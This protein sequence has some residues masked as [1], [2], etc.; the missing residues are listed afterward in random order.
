MRWAVLGE[1][2]P[3]REGVYACGLRFPKRRTRCTTVA[4]SGTDA[5]ERTLRLSVHHKVE[6]RNVAAAATERRV[7]GPCLAELLT[8]SNYTKRVYTSAHAPVAALCEA[9]NKKS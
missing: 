1:Q 6:A 2:L 4:A 3:R 7:S 5:V 9:A 8:P